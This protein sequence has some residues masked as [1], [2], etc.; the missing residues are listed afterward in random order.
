MITLKPENNTIEIPFTIADKYLSKALQRAGYDNIPGN[1]I[2]NKTLTGIGAT[3]QEIKAFR[4]SIIIE[5]NVPVIKGKVKAN[6]ECFGIYKGKKVK[7]IERYLQKPS[8]AY[9]KLLVTPE[10]FWKITE[11]A[12][13]LDIDIYA[14]Y[15]CLFDE[16]EKIGQ[17]LDYRKSI[18]FPINDFFQFTNKA[19]VSATPLKQAHEEFDKQNFRILK[20]KPDFDYKVSL[21]LTFTDTIR[22]TIDSKIQTLLDHGS[23]C[24]CIFFNSTKGIKAVIKS[25]QQYSIFC[26]ETSAKDLNVMG[27]KVHSD[28]N[29]L[30]L[31]RIN[32]FTS[33]YYSAVD[34]VLPQCPDVIIITDLDT[35]IHSMIDPYSEAI[36]IQGR[37]RNT[38]ANGNRFNSLSHITNLLLLDHLTQEEAVQELDVWFQ[39][40]QSL[41]QRYN[42]ATMSN[43]K[44][45]IEKEFKNCRIYPFLETPNLECEFKRNT[46]S[47]INKYSTERV[48]SYYSGEKLLQ[49][50]ED[51]E[52]FNI[53]YIDSIDHSFTF[54]FSL[55]DLAKRYNNP[56]ILQKTI[57]LDIIEQLEK[58]ITSESILSS[59]KN[60]T[61]AE[62]Y[63]DV[64]AVIEA[65]KLL[66]R[67]KLKNTF[68]A[69][70]KD[71]KSAKLFQT[72]EQKRFSSEVI[73]EIITE[74]EHDIKKQI[75]KSDIN[76]RLQK[77]YYKYS[78]VKKT[79]IPLV[80]TQLM[81]FD[82]FDGNNNNED[83][84]Y[85]LI[86]ILP[87]IYEKS[88]INS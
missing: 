39:T 15:F 45:A 32:F 66:G 41:K 74:F 36:Q 4:H 51:S 83:R 46:F 52:Y 64:Q 68:K 48:K 6:P 13:N 26:S 33:R 88:K 80:V 35:A 3:H 17:D 10:G 21:E 55:K 16:C 18:T 56:N 77:I 62:R 72:S 67:T 59:L 58:G 20:I 79:G 27:F 84:T 31:N 70:N 14:T 47:I 25:V 54:D 34:F 71:F 65:Y 9:K 40:A 38:H 87:D 49:A 73:N 57:I 8:P 12:Q 85:T 76:E 28:F 86:N 11:A 82:Y 22:K 44:K 42:N 63:K 1:A 78:L 53:D 69:I 75:P 23:K 29:P 43:E 61:N 50:Y 7:Q 24:I 37:F 30:Y 2:I 19:F 60:A 5:P 81:I